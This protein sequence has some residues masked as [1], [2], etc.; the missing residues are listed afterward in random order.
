M[1]TKQRYV[2]RA[3]ETRPYGTYTTEYQVVDT[4]VESNLAR[5]NVVG[6]FGTVKDAKKYI[7]VIES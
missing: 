5:Y 7:E 2:I 1:K 3:I 6:Q 4:T